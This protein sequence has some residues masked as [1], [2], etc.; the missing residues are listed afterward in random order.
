MIE[1]FLDTSYAISLSVV[2]DQKHTLA[3]EIAKQL[4]LDKTR[5]VVTRAVMLEIGNSLAKARYRTAAFALL[6]ALEHDP[7]VEIIE[8]GTEDYQAAMQLFQNRSDKEWGLV[9]C[10]SFIIMQRRGLFE[11]LTADGHFVQA[12]F[13]ALLLEKI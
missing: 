9:D 2:S 3:V 4:R 11:A 5:L 13:R 7:L 1:V 10:I 12:G 8:L 6:S